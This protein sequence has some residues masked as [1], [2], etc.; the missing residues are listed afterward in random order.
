MYFL[1][2]SMLFEHNEVYPESIVPFTAQFFFVF[3]QVS[4]TN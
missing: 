3:T 1:H 2:K 4:Q